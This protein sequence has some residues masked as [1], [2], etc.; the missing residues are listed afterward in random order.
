MSSA[1]GSEVREV[2]KVRDVNPESRVPQRFTKIAWLMPFFRIQFQDRALTFVLSA[3]CGDRETGVGTGVICTLYIISISSGVCTVANKYNPFCI[4]FARTWTT[5]AHAV[6]GDD[7]HRVHNLMGDAALSDAKSI[8]DVGA[9][10][11][12]TRTGGVSS[13]LTSRLYLQT[14]SLP[15]VPGTA[16][17]PP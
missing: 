10:S 14:R 17:G 15:P 16:M 4:V 12:P 6:A 9:S 11:D 13:D 3:C 8:I 7:R 2:R 5:L 1:M